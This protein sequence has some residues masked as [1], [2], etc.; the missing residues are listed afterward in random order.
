MRAK[1]RIDPKI[2][3]EKISKLSGLLKP[4][5]ITS[6][7]LKIWPNCMIQAPYAN[8]CSC[9]FQ[10]STDINSA[11]SITHA[12]IIHLLQQ[13]EQLGVDVIKTENLY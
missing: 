3:T 13:F 6:R 5:I 7:G 10:S 1:Q 8:H 12:D 4:I 9:R 2:F 11:P